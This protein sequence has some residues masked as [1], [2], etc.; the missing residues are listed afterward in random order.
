VKPVF[1]LGPVELSSYAVMLSLGGSIGF[2]LTWREI[3]RKRLEPGPMLGLAALAFVCGVVGA[4]GLSLL[5]YRPL[6]AEEPWWSLLAVWDR[7]GMAMY[8]GLVLA[9][10]AGLVY[11]RLRRLPAW[12]AA[13]TLAAAWTPLIVFMRVGCF[14]NGCCYGRPTTSA[15]GIVAGGSPDSV[16]FGIP[17]HPAQ[18]YDA[19]AALVLSVLL[20]HLRTRRRFEG[21]LA[22]TFLALYPAWRI[23]HE[24]LR[25]DPWVAFRFGRLVLL[26]LNQLVSA[27]LVV[28]A[29]AAG[30]V[31]YARGVRD[32]D[33][34]S[35][36]QSMPTTPSGNA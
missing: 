9:G 4:R 25:G 26:T 34:G 7:G 3:Q 31:L 33:R 20:W 21:Q 6:Y 8:G 14:L 24:T 11:I 30:L 28:F 12:D 10:A 2:W 27:G 15:L 16:N 23:F 22:L 17:S 32:R 5:I 36:S 35:R 1:T 13:D 19:A 18:L 29:A